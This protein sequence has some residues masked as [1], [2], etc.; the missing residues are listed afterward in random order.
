M[1][2]LLHRFVCSNIC[3]HFPVDLSAYLF[4]PNMF[5]RIL[6][7]NNL[8]LIT[9]L[10]IQVSFAYVTRGLSAE[11]LRI[12]RRNNPLIQNQKISSCHFLLNNVFSE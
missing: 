10:S 2:L 8:F 5:L 1:F 3:F 4:F 11:F 7:S 6:L 9:Y 12:M